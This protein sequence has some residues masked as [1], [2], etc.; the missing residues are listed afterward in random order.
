MKKAY[1]ILFL[2][3]GFLVQTAVTASASYPTGPL[4]ADQIAEQVFLVSHGKL[5]S[6]SSST[7]NKMDISLV[8][9]RAP[10]EKRKPGRK[11]TVNT[12]E[13][14]GKSQPSDPE[15]ES[16]QMAVITSGKI[17]GTGTLY[18]NYKDPDKGDVLSFWLPALR[19]I[20]RINQPAHDD[21]WI[22]SNLTYGELVLR[23]PEHETHE[24]LGEEVLAGCLATMELKE[25]EINRYTKRLPKATC[26]HEGKPVYRV[27]S[28][29]KFKNWWY[30][31]HISEIDKK[32]F[33]IYRTVYY[34]NNEK[35]KT[36]TVDWQSLEQEDPR[37][38]FPRY[39]YAVSHED[40]SDT[41][42]Y[43]PIKTIT[44]NPDI[45]DSFWSEESL[46]KLGRA[47]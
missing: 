14:Y 17:K 6:S 18:K 11:P 22:G 27:K 32:T 20:R 34:K 44:L 13:T 26:S 15:F 31:Y 39:I 30:D 42:I 36:I 40:G 47:L 43:V 29:T 33:G 19:K 10:S 3:P 7:K 35:I 12:F 24:L 2:L 5:L 41:M 21:K 28:F 38:I 16:L 45:P 4:T 46:K 37:I 23:R 8:V 1:L 9:T 25:W